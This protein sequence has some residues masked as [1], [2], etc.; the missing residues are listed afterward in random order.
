MSRYETDSS[1]FGLVS[2]IRQ[3]A[4]DMVLAAEPASL[5][6]PEARKGR[7]Y[8]IAETGA[9][10]ARGRDAC[11]LVLKTIRKVFYEDSSYSVT[12]ALRKA[13]QVANRALYQHNFSAPPQ[14]RAV[15]GLSC[16]VIKDQDLYLAQVLPAQA[17]VLS[18][19]K[20]RALPAIAAWGGAPT[21]T[22]PRPGALGF[23]L[24]TEPDFYR[25]VL[26]PGDSLLLCSSNLSALLGRE[27]TDGLLR[28]G[29]AAA[30]VDELAALGREAGLTEAHGIA[31]RLAPPL[32]PAAQAAPLSPVGVAERGRLLARFAG[33]RVARLTGE[34]AR[35]ARPGARQ[36][37]T[38]TERR[39][40]RGAREEELLQEQ[41]PEPEP[42][43]PSVPRP[44]ELRLGESLEE[45][46]VQERQSRLLRAAQP[47][48][49]P[50]EET[51]PSAFLG[52]HNHYAAGP[53]RRIDLSDTPG[54][55]ALG[56][57]GRYAGR[58]PLP[59]DMTLGERLMLPLR[60]ASEA[61]GRATQRRR[62]RRPPPSALR[63]AA[64]PRGLSYRREG[65]QVPWVLL[66]ALLV[67]V[68]G[69]V[70]YGRM[71]VTDN[72]R[73]EALEALDQAERAVAAVRDAP[74]E[75]AA[76][77][78][79]DEARLAINRVE[80]AGVITSTAANRERLDRLQRDY[81]QNLATVQKLTYFDDLAEIGRHPQAG[82][83][84]TFQSI[85]V[86]PPPSGITNTLGFSSIYALDS[87]SGVLYSLPKAG[88]A[89]QPFLSP[90]DSFLPGLRVGKVRA[91][92][93]RLDNV[94]AI[95]QS[96]EGPFIY[97][98]R[99]GDRWN[100]SNLGG[101]TE[102]NRVSDTPFH[103]AT[104]AGNLYV[105]GAVP[106][107]VLKYLSGQPADP[108]DPWIKD[109]S[110]AT[111]TA[112][113]LAIDGNVYLL[114]PGGGVLVYEANAFKREIPPPALKQPLVT[115]SGFAVS[116]QSPESGSI[117]LLDT[118]NERLI[119]IDK[120]SGTLIQ[121]I[122]AR[123]DSDLRLSALATFFVDDSG[124]QKQIYLINGSQI[125]RATLPPPPPPFRSAATPTQ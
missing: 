95:A 97:Y 121:Q 57:Q 43:P 124:P 8:I 53:D 117:F 87:N 55:A 63:A 79:L 22:A 49:R 51:P 72:A 33:E 105:W 69:L 89:I 99:A 30:A 113:D 65:P 82:A 109:A 2:G 56:A 108:Y 16:A 36:Q 92:A 39:L 81:E 48:A 45:R 23:S 10:V 112:I 70:F 78:Q 14:K 12:S 41:H 73:R 90:D 59:I 116:G 68:A 50:A 125:L 61:V 67:L 122:R 25:A 7:L 42:P 115:A 19:G 28:A 118:A 83:G 75:A 110:R 77:R 103:L 107:Q 64:R 71:L 9:D 24:T 100:G 3:P 114:Q 15:V 93:W 32:S 98:F 21:Q 96:S 119:E 18:G 44:R 31:V 91:I 101:S 4:S 76:E 34:L 40:E 38:K 74:D 52:E 47:E 54:M 106:G 88:G 13:I 123:P 85:V 62:L 111:D 29:A 1:Q 26:G 58:E 17:Y 5:F 6:A 86:P 11:Q 46:V 60:R 84:G 94:V 120:I 37:Q 104:Y 66:V 80:S 102:W 27:Q 35:L 20:L